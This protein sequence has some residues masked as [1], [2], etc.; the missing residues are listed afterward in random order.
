[1]GW[2]LLFAVLAAVCI[3]GGTILQAI[4]AR[5]VRRYQA[6]DPRLLLSVIRSVPFVLG[7]VLLIISF[8]LT[9]VAL[10]NTALFVVQ[11]LAAA[12][13]AL[14]A[15]VS[16]AIFRTRLH[17]VEWSA[18]AAVCGGVA[19]LVIT[20]RPS[21]ASTLPAIGPWALLIAAVVIAV[22]ALTAHRGLSGV[23]IPGMLAG[24]AFGDAAVAS[25]VVAKIDGSALA[26]LG[27]PATYAVVVSGLIGTLLYATSLQ[28][29]SVT[30]VFGLSTVG[31]TIG[32]AVT[33]WLLLGDSVQRGAAPVAG[34]GFGLA[35][36][37]ALVLGRHAHPDQVGPPRVP[38]ETVDE[39]RPPGPPA[40]MTV[41]PTSVV[42]VAPWPRRI[43]QRV[44]AVIRAA[45][46][47]VLAVRRRKTA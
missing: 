25:R 10:R 7:L 44:L 30:A 20:Q 3:A 31:Q 40:P 16:A 34:V 32:P 42:V 14:V 39:R 9:L 41:Q 33:G 2:G 46:R 28:R 43:G 6:I 29:G 45:A 13:I 22:V 11:A 38:L 24:L 21:T 4:G 27:T 36:V 35:V 37:G 18:V 5:R 15:A 12:S 17:W 8:V 23:A 47:R 19:L 26:L 1:V